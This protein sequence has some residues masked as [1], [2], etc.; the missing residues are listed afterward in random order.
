MCQRAVKPYSAQFN[1][2]KYERSGLEPSSD[3]ELKYK[4]F[5]FVG[6]LPKL[7]VHDYTGLNYLSYQKSKKIA[8]SK[9]GIQ[10]VIV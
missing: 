2:K 3:W 8:K 6:K 10:S 5:F 1:P 9:E 7:I 4:E